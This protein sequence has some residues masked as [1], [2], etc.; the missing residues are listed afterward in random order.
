MTPIDESNSSEVE[1]DEKQIR[2]G[3]MASDYA[4]KMPIERKESWDKY[5]TTKDVF[6]PA[7][8]KHTDFA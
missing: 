2:S 6:V 1:H 3:S 8:E 4:Y 7:S 5:L